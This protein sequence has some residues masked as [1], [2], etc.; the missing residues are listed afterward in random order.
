MKKYLIAVSI[1]L[2]AMS[3][4]ITESGSNNAYAL[5][6]CTTANVQIS[7]YHHLALT[8]CDD[9]SGTAYHTYPGGLYC[10]QT[11]DGQGAEFERC[12]A[13]RQLEP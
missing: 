4:D 5:N 7:N 6:S 10:V 3:Y 12:G 11:W 8:V 1:C 9:G 2:L 13:I